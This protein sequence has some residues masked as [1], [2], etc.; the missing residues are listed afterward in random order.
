MC[1]GTLSTPFWCL[2]Q[3]LSL[4]PLYF[5]K[6]LLHKRSEWSSLVSGPGLNSSPPGAKNP[7][8]LF[9]Q[10]QPWIFIGRSDAEAKAPILWPP[11][12]NSWPTDAGKDW[13]QEKGAK[14]DKMV[15]RHHWFSGH[16]FEQTQG[17][18]EG[19]GSLVCCNSWGRKEW[20]MTKQLNNNILKLKLSPKSQYF[21]LIAYLA[22]HLILWVCTASSKRSCRSS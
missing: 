22:K 21:P 9:I 2:C 16:E 1:G 20:D 11:E 6:T 10:N 12:A 4:S 8:I 13:G 18:S 7:S 19:Q 15:G 14:E 17:D 5:N 3:K